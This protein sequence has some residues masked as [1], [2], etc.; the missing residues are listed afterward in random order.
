MRRT[1]PLRVCFQPFEGR[2]WVCGPSSLGAVVE[3]VARASLICPRCALRCKLSQ[4][5]TRGA[6][7]ELPCWR[8]RAFWRR[9]RANELASAP[10]SG[11]DLSGH[12]RSTRRTATMRS[13]SCRVSWRPAT[14]E[15]DAAAARPAT[16]RGGPRRR[17]GGRRPNGTGDAAGAVLDEG[18]RWPGKDVI[19]QAVGHRG[20]LLERRQRPRL[21]GD[22]GQGSRRIT[23]AATRGRGDA[24]PPRCGWDQ[25][26][27]VVQSGEPEEDRP[28]YEQRFSLSADGQRLVESSCSRAG[29]RMAFTA[30]RVG[31]CA[32]PP[33]DVAPD[34][35][36]QQVAIKKPG[37]SPA[38]KSPCL[39][40][41]FVGSRAG[42]VRSVLLPHAIAF[43]QHSS[44]EQ[45]AKLVFL[46]RNAKINCDSKA[47]SRAAGRVLH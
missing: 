20:H 25:G 43:L 24:P 21:P 32:P 41:R 13:G 17:G 40:R 12:W 7:C 18:L 30:S 3:R 29:A 11:V 6:A 35:L 46:S 15:R 27:L 34:V 42:D 47:T 38:F 26:T 31:S 45:L 2:V 8:G 10:P 9:A 1:E 36:C 4:H 33:S 39:S 5:F 19:D 22:S 16:G 14:A 44:V 37:V 23:G 28:P